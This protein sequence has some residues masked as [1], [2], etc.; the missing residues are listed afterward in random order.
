MAPLWGQRWNE[1]SEP[2]ATVAGATYP[3]TAQEPWATPPTGHV[4]AIA[5]TFGAEKVCQGLPTWCEVQPWEVTPSLSQA[6]LHHCPWLAG[7][8]GLGDRL[9][10]KPT[11]VFGNA[12]A[13]LW[14]QQCHPHTGDLGLS[15]L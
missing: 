11:G 3:V 9:C 6:T 5:V 7:T 12:P 2:Q 10:D 15:T 4:P 14:G 8:Q 1:P 13:L